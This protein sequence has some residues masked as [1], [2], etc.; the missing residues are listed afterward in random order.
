MPSIGTF[1]GVSAGRCDGVSVGRCDG[2]SV[3]RCDG[4]SVGR[5]DGVSVGRC[6]GVSVGRCD[7]VSVGKFIWRLCLFWGGAIVWSDL[8]I[9]YTHPKHFSFL[10]AYTRREV[11]EGK[12]RD[13]GGTMFSE[14]EE[15][16]LI[17]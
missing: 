8:L 1:D 16:E 2:V 5:F 15:E 9:Q 13:A 10:G 17:W 6:D 14:G 11:G 4:V 12:V 7:G 3:G